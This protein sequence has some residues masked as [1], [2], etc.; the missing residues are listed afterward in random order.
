MVAKAH[1]EALKDKA[2]VLF[3]AVVIR[4]INGREQTLINMT[5]IPQRKKP[6]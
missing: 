1:V 2:S 3:S 6:I 5:P 4:I